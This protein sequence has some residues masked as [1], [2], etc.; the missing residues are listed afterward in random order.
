MYCKTLSDLRKE[1]KLCA[2][3]TTMLM[4]IVT[5]VALCLLRN[6]TI[7]AR[8]LEPGTIQEILVRH[9]LVYPVTFLK[10]IIFRNDKKN[11]SPRATQCKREQT[12]L[13]PPL[14]TLITMKTLLF[15]KCK[16]SQNNTLVGQAYRPDE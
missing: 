11:P 16:P 3:V 7:P 15:S 5:D 12:H 4:I 10:G 6:G 8:C 9:M 14:F 13:I 2:V 1:R